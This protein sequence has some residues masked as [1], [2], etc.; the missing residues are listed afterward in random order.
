MSSIPELELCFCE[1]ITIVTHCWTGDNAGR[2]YVKC[3]G[4]HCI[5]DRWIEDSLEGHATIIIETLME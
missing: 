3:P 1:K 5:Y 4:D 2:K